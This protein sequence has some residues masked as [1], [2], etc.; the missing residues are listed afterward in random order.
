[1]QT[2]LIRKVA[3][4]F[5]RTAICPR[6]KSGVAASR[7]WKN[8]FPMSFSYGL[9]TVLPMII[10]KGIPWVCVRTALQQWQKT[11]TVNFVVRERGSDYFRQGGQNVY[12]RC[13]AVADGSGR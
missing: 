11:Y 9:Q 12:A 4:Y 10:I 2:S 7:M 6:L 13:Y 3:L 5:S 1:I 8:Q